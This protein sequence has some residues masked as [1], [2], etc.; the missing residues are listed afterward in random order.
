[1]KFRFDWP[2]KFQT[3][4]FYLFF[5][6]YKFFLGFF[7]PWLL[8]IIRPFIYFSIHF[9]IPKLI[10]IAI[11]KDNSSKFPRLCIFQFILSISI[12]I[13]LSK[14]DLV[15]TK[16]RSNF[17]LDDLAGNTT[18]A[19]FFQLVSSFFMG[20]VQISSYEGISSLYLIHCCWYIIFLCCINLDCSTS[21]M[22]KY[23]TL[24]CLVR[25]WWLWFFTRWMT[26]WL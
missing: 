20:R 19:I 13:F 26:L 22:Q 3:V 21:R 18:N 7:I 2:H 1:M 12:I 24:I 15:R 9:P 11:F 6:H 25:K 17:L 10:T 5:S 8:W 4:H 23:Q 14:V 16:H